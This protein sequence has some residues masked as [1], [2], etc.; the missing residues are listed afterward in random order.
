MRNPGYS[1]SR[2]RGVKC[3]FGLVD[4]SDMLEDIESVVRES[5]PVKALADR[6]V[7]DRDYGPSLSSLKGVFVENECFSGAIRPCGPSTEAS[8]AG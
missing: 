3:P 7:R 1:P 2:G 6:G 8:A 5:A 4:E